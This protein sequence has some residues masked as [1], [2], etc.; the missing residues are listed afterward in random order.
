[1]AE[2]LKGNNPLADSRYRYIGK[3]LDDAMLGH[4]LQLG[5]LGP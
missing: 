1:M 3:L 4:W 5:P 2:P